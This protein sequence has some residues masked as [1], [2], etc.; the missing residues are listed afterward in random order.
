M[1]VL[2]KFRDRGKKRIESPRDSISCHCGYGPHAG[3]TPPFQTFRLWRTQMSFL[4]RKSHAFRT[5]FFIWF[6]TG[7]LIIYSIFVYS[8]DYGTLIM[9]KP[10]TL[11]GE[12]VRFYG[13]GLKWLH[14][15]R[16]LLRMLKMWWFSTGLGEHIWILPEHKLFTSKI[17]YNSLLFF[18]NHNTKILVVM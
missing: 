1:G 7:E 12:V 4:N 11:D 3:P 18:I 8:W 9:Y 2:F 10:F 14:C 16:D 13:T 15:F 17:G 5:L 6:M